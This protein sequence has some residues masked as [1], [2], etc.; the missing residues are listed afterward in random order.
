[1]ASM[2][3]GEMKQ[4]NDRFQDIL[5]TDLS[6]RNNRLEA[7]S[8]DLVTT[9]QDVDDYHAAMMYLAISDE[10]QEKID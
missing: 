2:T 3:F 7:M 8:N 1:M 9:Y 5:S 10:V 4:W 6:L